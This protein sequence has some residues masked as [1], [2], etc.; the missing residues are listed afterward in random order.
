M[1]IQT[2]VDH[3]VEYIECYNSQNLNGIRTYLDENCEVFVNGQLAA[4]GRETMIPSYMNDFAQK[5]QAILQAL[6]ADQCSVTDSTA[7]V[8]VT[9]QSDQT[10]LKVAY[11]FSTATHRMI[12][13][14][15]QL[16]Q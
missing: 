16:S 11:I 14:H 15:I 13:H 1:D 12:Q 6:H 2:Y 10:I 7:S 4:S 3:L 8:V 9:L 5:K